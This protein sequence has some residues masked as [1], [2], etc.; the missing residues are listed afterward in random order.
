MRSQ[1]VGFRG[2]QGHRGQLTMEE[3]LDGALE[4]DRED[5]FDMVEE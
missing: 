5:K 1:V 2:D 3:D 4:L